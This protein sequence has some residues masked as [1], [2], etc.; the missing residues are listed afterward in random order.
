MVNKER[1]K[2]TKRTERVVLIDDDLL[3]SFFSFF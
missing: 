1:Q 3:I 2:V